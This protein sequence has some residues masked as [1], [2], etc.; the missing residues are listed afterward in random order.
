MSL[1]QYSQL[2][3]Y[4][5]AAEFPWLLSCKPV[6]CEIQWNRVFQESDDGMHNI[7][8]N[9]QRAESHTGAVTRFVELGRDFCIFGFCE[10]VF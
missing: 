10:N 9:E 3:F 1:N 7:I 8:G 2:A 4:A 6:V 5:L